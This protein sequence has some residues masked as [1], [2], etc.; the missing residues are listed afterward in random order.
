MNIYLDIEVQQREL[1]ARVIFAAEAAKRG[2]KTYFGHKVNLYPL[3]KKLKPGI[4]FHKSIQGHK[5]KQIEQLKSL[6]HFNVSI[7]EEGLN[8]NCDKMYFHYKL[9][10]KCLSLV[11]AFF[12]WGEDDKNLISKNFNESKDKIYIAGNSRV[13]LLKNPLFQEKSSRIAIKIWRVSFSQPSSEDVIFIK[14]LG[15]LLNL[16]NMILQKN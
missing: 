7:D 9:S 15:I 16:G 4:F 13:D 6:G 11:D 1:E 5:L 8:R 10:R 14:I 12:S 2:H 3:I